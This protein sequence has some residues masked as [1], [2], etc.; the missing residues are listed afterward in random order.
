MGTRGVS[1]LVPVSWLLPWA[2]AGRP[3]LHTEPAHV[4]REGRDAPRTCIV[5]ASCERGRDAHV[6]ILLPP[7]YGVRGV[8]PLMVIWSGT[9]HFPYRMIFSYHN[10]NREKYFMPSKLISYFDN[11]VIW[12][13]FI[14]WFGG[15]SFG[16]LAL[17]E[18]NQSPAMDKI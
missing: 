6:S 2:W 9:L 3:R 5:G 14:R 11:S 13:I 4:W 15:F 10:C 12:R 1:P 18:R 16:G 7:L 8:P 17:S